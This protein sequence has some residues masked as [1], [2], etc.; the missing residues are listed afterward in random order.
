MPRLSGAA[1]PQNGRG[2][3]FAGL[4]AV[5][6]LGLGGC[7]GD[8][9]ALSEACAA[10][11]EGIVVAANSGTGEWARQGRSGRLV[12]LWRVGGTNEGQELAYPSGLVANAQGRLAVVDF[13]LGQVI[14]VENDGRWT[15]PL[16]GRGGGP[17]ELQTAVAAGWTASGELQVFD[18]G[19]SKVVVFGPSGVP[20]RDDPVDRSFVQPVWESG[21]LGWAAVGDDGAVFLQGLPEGGRR[22]AASTYGAAP[23][24][25]LPSASATP[26]T[27]VN[28]EFPVVS[29]DGWMSTLSPGWPQPL[30]A[31]GSGGRVATSDSSAAYRIRVR[32]ETDR[33]LVVCRD[34]PSLAL[35]ED[36][37]GV[38]PDN[39]YAPLMQAI[40]AAPP[41]PEPAPFGRF[42]LS[43][44]GRLWV[45][46]ERPKPTDGF[47]HLGGAGAAWDVFDQDGLFL[48]EVR[49][50]GTAR[51]QAA[52]GDTVYA[53]V[54]GE[55]D[56]PWVVAFRLEVE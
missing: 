6:A 14:V 45:Q 4:A 43:T 3:W 36:E 24:L 37:R 53:F 19:G 39:E 9:S 17:G 44:E 29:P 15:G 12:E 50:P 25:R 10:G 42:F 7:G 35:D 54:I 47:K 46:R 48:G 41:P 2:L 16:G 55:L 40:R 1:G 56:E 28:F 21:G 23:I 27:L 38:S 5:I 22:E 34:A 11:E 52:S 20:I 13:Q 32:R 51:L 31:V 30:A 8:A 26:E 33:D 18:L 49:A